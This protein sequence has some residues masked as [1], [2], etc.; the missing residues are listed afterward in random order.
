MSAPRTLRHA[1]LLL[2]V[3]ALPLGAQTAVAINP[4]SLPAVTTIDKRFQSY[5]IE[6]LEV[7]GGRFWKPYADKSAKPDDSKAA[8]APSTDATPAGMS[9]DM[10]AY[11]APKDLYN[12]RLRK[13]AAALGPA[14]VRVSGTWAN[15]TYFPAPG[16]TLTAPP[17]GF[18]GILTRPQWKGVID[19][20][21]ATN[22]EIVTSFSTGVGTRDASGAWRPV[23][24]Q[25][26]LDY[27]ALLHGN[28]AAAEYMNE[29]T[30]AALGGAPKGYDAAQYG[31]DFATF[32]AFIRASAPA[33]KVAGPGSVGESAGTG[34]NAGIGDAMPGFIST[35]K[36]L[37]AMGS[38]NVDIFSY[39]MYGG[40]SQRCK[41]MAAANQA[42]PEAAL[43]E[44]WLA[45]TDDVLAYYTK[46]RDEFDPGKP[47]W[48]T[49]TGETACGGNPWAATFLDSFRYLDQLGRLAKSGVKVAMHNTLAASDYGLLDEN[50]YA[51]RPNFWAALLWRRFMGTTVLDSTVPLQP[52]L[53]VYAHCLSGH[54]AGGVAL[55]VIQNDPTAPHTLT[56]PTASE[57]YTLSAASAQLA[58]LQTQSIQ[59]NNTALTLG[60][61]DTLPKLTP[62]A[63]PAGPVTFAPATITFLTL[64]KANNPA[65]R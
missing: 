47:L 12:A 30:F 13:L 1:T 59:L 14:Y 15:T 32:L 33:L 27:T 11:R 48:L 6:M 41:L 23:Q 45:T 49:E 37:A 40:V 61:N 7:T 52:G 46:E 29:P 17:A 20:A 51:P 57:R 64:P 4:A 18:G 9:A 22:S 50:T 19:F 36:L 28:I 58:A 44:H 24:A 35:P 16:E 55:L 31:R 26:L 54:A 8:P 38:N 39:H 62:I 25:R 34:I 65:C 3:T 43:S 42:T 5:N 63:T 2:A 21:H 10:Y 60:P 53:H 56:L